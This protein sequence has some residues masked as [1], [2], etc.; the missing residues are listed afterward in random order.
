VPLVL[1]GPVSVWLGRF[2]A[3]RRWRELGLL[4]TPEEQSPPPVVVELQSA[5]E[6]VVDGG[7][8]FTSAVLHPKKNQLHVA[9]ARRRGDTAYRRAR[10][11]E[12]VQRCVESGPDALTLKEKV[13]ILEDA[14]ALQTLHQRA[15]LCDSSSPWATLIER[16]CH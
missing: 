4:N 11:D 14:V 9:L 10:R 12:L 8:A 2:R 7:S 6:E 3:G 15:W 13:W 5:A 16:L 1:A